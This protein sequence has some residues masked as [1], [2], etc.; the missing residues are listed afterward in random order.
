MSVINMK[1]LVI[2]I[3]I[4]ICLIQVFGQKTKVTR[5]LRGVTEIEAIKSVGK[6]EFIIGA[7]SWFEKNISQFGEIDLDVGIGY[8]PFKFL[9][10]DV[11][12]RWSKNRNKYDQFTERHRINGDIN[13]I[14]KY[15]RFKIDYRVCYQNIDDN[16]F[17]NEMENP[18]QHIIRNRMQIKYNIRNSKLTPYI[19]I[20]HYGQLGEKVYG[21]KIKPEIGIS[22]P[23]GKNHE[24]K[25]YYRI[26]RELHNELPST[27]FSLGLGYLFDF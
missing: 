23:F 9:S 7:K 26:D 25:A 19:S 21:L 4:Q 22:Y 14:V 24:L 6:F 12:Y 20:E 27:F 2:I 13:F 17:Q 3:F 15:K 1:R 10:L 8:K 11:G 18:S 5:D 16:L